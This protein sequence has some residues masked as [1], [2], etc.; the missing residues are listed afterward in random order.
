MMR[1]AKEGIFRH[2]HY[3]GHESVLFV[4]DR[5][6]GLQ[7]IVAVHST[8]LGPALGGCRIWPYPDDSYALADALRLSQSMTFK[9]AAADVPFGGGKMVVIAEPDMKRPALL[10]A[11]GAAIERLGGAYITGEDVGAGAAEM[12]EIS[13][14]TSHVCGLPEEAGGSGDPSPNT[15]LGCLE[16]LR[17]AVRFRLNGKSLS[18][19][20]VA[21]QGLGNVGWRLCELLHGEGARLIVS[22]IRPELCAHAADAFAAKT[23]PPNEIHATLA[24]VFAP[25]ALGDAINHQ[26]AGELR[27]PIIAGAANNQLAE[28]NLADALR[29]LNILYAPD[30]IIN[31]GGLIQ[32][33]GE[34][35]RWSSAEVRERVLHIGGTLT[36]IFNSMQKDDITTLGAAYRL[37]LARLGKTS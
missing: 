34:R 18:G 37:V 9:A 10:R 12:I 22:D 4:R 16:G 1:I 21:I 5:A 13:R 36:E 19:V 15:A 30:F 8:K 23:V 20:T 17:A 2:R 7:A 25:C 11:V 28:P 35:L 33:A 29:K 24:D 32:L 3:A 6:A 14:T 27:A 26:T 31:A